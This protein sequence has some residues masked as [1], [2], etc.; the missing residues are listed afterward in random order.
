[1][2]SFSFYFQNYNSAT[3]NDEKHTESIKRVYLEVKM[4]H[5]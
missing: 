3:N 2:K 4:E 5:P 1:M